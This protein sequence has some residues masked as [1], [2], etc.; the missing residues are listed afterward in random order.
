MGQWEL[1]AEEQGA[2]SG[3]DTVKR[4]HQLVQGDSC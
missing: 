4:K 1:T 2:V 3:S